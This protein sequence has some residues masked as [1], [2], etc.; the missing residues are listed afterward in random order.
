MAPLYRKFGLDPDKVM[1]AFRELMTDDKRRETL[2]KSSN[3]F[4]VLVK[5]LLN[6][7]IITERTRSF[8]AVYID[9][10]ELKGEGDRMIGDDIADEGIRYLQEINFRDRASRM[11]AE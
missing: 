2:T 8:Y 11:A 3:I 9:M 1:V 5:T 10:D 6:A 7:G 4:R